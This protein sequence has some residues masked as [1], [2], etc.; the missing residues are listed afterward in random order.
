VNYA[1]CGNED[2]NEEGLLLFDFEDIVDNLK[3]IADEKDPKCR[4]IIMKA[5]DIGCNHCLFFSDYES[6]IGYFNTYKYATIVPFLHTNFIRFIGL[7]DPS[8]FLAFKVLN[9]KY[10][11]LHNKGYLVTWNLITGKVIGLK[12]L[13]KKWTMKY[14][15]HY[16]EYSSNRLLDK[17]DGKVLLRSKKEI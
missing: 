16:P 10:I 5:Y 15:V 8:K 12:E 6:R 11:A 14:E 13:E 1:I 7:S 17:R 4:S 3:F 2:I 9:D